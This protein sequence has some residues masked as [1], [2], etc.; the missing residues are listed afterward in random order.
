MKLKYLSHLLLFSSLLV[1]ILGLFTNPDKAMSLGSSF[2]GDITT[3]SEINK[4][5]LYRK[6]QLYSDQQEI[7]PIDAKIDRVN[8]S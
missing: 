5:D 3:S 8:N 4:D 1:L 2:K 7:E 6:I